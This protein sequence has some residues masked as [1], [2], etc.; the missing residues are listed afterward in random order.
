MHTCRC[1][2]ASIAIALILIVIVFNI[3]LYYY[4]FHGE[5]KMYATKVVQM[6]LLNS[7]YLPNYYNLTKLTIEKYNESVSNFNFEGEVFIDLD[8]SVYLRVDMY[9]SKP[10]STEFDQWSFHLP[11]MTICTYNSLYYKHFMMEDLKNNSNFPQFGPDDSTCS[12]K[13]SD[14]GQMRT[15][16]FL[17]RKKKQSALR[18]HIYSIV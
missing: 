15:N 4:L 16:Q 13:V 8:E 2:C 7:S 11:N 14:S 18:V 10:N 1:Y 12:K 3:A 6:Q 9:H 5:K 17:P